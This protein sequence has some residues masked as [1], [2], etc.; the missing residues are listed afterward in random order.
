MYFV[1]TCTI[2][3]L[4]IIV[5]HTQAIHGYTVNTHRKVPCSAEKLVPPTELM[6]RPQALRFAYHKDHGVSLNIK[7]MVSLQKKEDP[8]ERERMDAILKHVHECEV[9]EQLHDQQLREA[10]HTT[11]SILELKA[12]TKRKE[13]GKEEPKGKILG[14]SLDARDE[15]S[16]DDSGEEEDEFDDGDSVDELVK[17]G[18]GGGIGHL[19]LDD[20]D[21]HS[22]ELAERT[23]R[24]TEP[25][26]SLWERRQTNMGG[27]AAALGA[28]RL[29]RPTKSKKKKKTMNKGEMGGEFDGD[30]DFVTDFSHDDGTYPDAFSFLEEWKEETRKDGKIRWK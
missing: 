25:K 22:D 9:R 7:K 2:P 4:S 28:T 13:N 20:V 6:T 23:E 1:H 27:V 18:A 8:E 17:M 30:G 10:G 26:L 15:D 19:G 3:Y 12:T 16:S 24:V 29:N 11:E 21:H 5:Q 14:R